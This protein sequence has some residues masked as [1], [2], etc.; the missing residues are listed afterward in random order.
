MK[1]HLL[2]LHLYYDIF[3]KIL[4]DLHTPLFQQH[5]LSFVEIFAP[6]PKELDGVSIA[7]TFTLGDAS[8]VKRPGGALIFHFPWYNGEPESSIR[9]GDFK[10]LKNLD[11]QAVA[12][13]KLSADLSEKNDLKSYYPEMAASL[14][15]QMIEYLDS[16][17][18]EEVNQLRAGFLKN[19][20]GEW[21]T[22]AEARV[23]SSRIAAAAGN[24][25]A[26][27]QLAE[28][29]K[30][31]KWLKQEAIFTRERMAMSE[32]SK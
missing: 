4:E 15:Q 6:L 24:T 19:I 28:A 2:P 16:V 9:R 5:L 12:L 11:T 3:P 31:I 1:A 26:Q 29:E 21:L 23:D 27:Q 13:Y 18:A 7:E 22:K 25:Q 8:E 30:Y 17:G 32:G 10:L 20:E 14:E